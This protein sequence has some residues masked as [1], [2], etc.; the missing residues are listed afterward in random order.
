MNFMDFISG[1]YTALSLSSGLFF[2]TS[3]KLRAP[4]REAFGWLSIYCAIENLLFF[5]ISNIRISDPVTSQL[6]GLC[7]DMTTIPII[8]LV[9]T[10]IAD[11]DMRTTPFRK[12]WLRVALLEIPILVCL[13]VSVFTQFEWRRLFAVVVLLFNVVSIFSYSFYKLVVYEKRLPADVKG[14]RASV[15][16]MWNLVALLAIEIVL[17]LSVG[18]YISANIYF[19][20]LIL[21][22]CVATYFIDKQSP[23]D[24]RKMYAIRNENENGNENGSENGTAQ[25]GLSRNDMRDRASQFMA[26]HPHFADRMA[27]R[28]KQK[29][30]VRDM[31]LCIMIVEGRTVSEIA[32]ILA[33]S[34]TSVDVARYRLR[35]K[36]DLNRGENLAKVLKSF[37]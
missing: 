3:R 8:M 4:F 19:V 29:I 14:K 5:I 26:K 35:S 1:F 2:L 27:E 31:F 37:M 36:L 32:E 22:T 20:V 10:T 24:T 15:K 30:T 17:Y 7:L 25:Q 13:C 23:I 34:P 18:T 28:A 16:W 9:I 6:V 21:F 33:I 12:R 11:Q